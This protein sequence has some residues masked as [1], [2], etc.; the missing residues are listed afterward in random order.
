[1]SCIAYTAGLS[2]VPSPLQ[3]QQQQQQSSFVAISCTA[4][5]LGGIEQLRMHQ[6]LFAQSSLTKLDLRNA[7]K[8]PRAV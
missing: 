6:Q 1:M 5:M 4:R 7:S 3:Q 2:I 8:S